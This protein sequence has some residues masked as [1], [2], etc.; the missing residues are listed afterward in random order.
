MGRF[1]HL[2]ETEVA[3]LMTMTN[4][5]YVA[6]LLLT[7]HLLPSMLARGTGWIVN[8]NSPVS[9]LPW[10]GATGYAASRWALR[11]LT[12]VLRTDLR[13]T[14]VGVSEVVPAK[15]RSAYF[16][17]N[18][19]AEE[20]IPSIARLVPALSPEQVA[21]AMVRAVEREKTEVLL[22]WQLRGLDLAGRFFPAATAYLSWRTGERRQS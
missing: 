19:G 16:S 5:P 8:V 9:R 7:R 18:P 1:L 12:A 22:P 11:G 3:E 13:G 6:A 21:K 14:G 15:V 4:V 17:H 20:R 2:D 10:P